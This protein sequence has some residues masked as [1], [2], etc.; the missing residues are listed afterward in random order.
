MMSHQ[1]GLKKQKKTE[2]HKLII[3]TSFGPLKVVYSPKTIAPTAPA[4]RLLQGQAG[5]QAS[6]ALLDDG[7]RPLRGAQLALP[8]AHRPLGP[9]REP[10]FG[11]EDA[12]GL[13]GFVSMDVSSI[14][15]VKMLSHVD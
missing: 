5:A 8:R 13:F 7:P 14:D 4:L 12:L 3:G 6:G 15:V 1:P 9:L 10:F 11:T 2:A